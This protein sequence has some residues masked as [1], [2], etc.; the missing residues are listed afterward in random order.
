V[1][2]V[3]QGARSERTGH[4]TF[5]GP[6]SRC[7]AACTERLAQRCRYRGGIERRISLDDD[8]TLEVTEPCRDHCHHG[9]LFHGAKTTS[10]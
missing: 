6:E 5:P 1:V 3:E 7:D 10:P 4:P 2:T 9:P 8:I